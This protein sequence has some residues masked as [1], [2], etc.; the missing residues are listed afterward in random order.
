MRPTGTKRWLLLLAVGIIT[1]G[2]IWLAVR[3]G[4]SSTPTKAA[5]QTATPDF[6]SLP[7]NYL[8]LKPSPTKEF[9]DAKAYILVDGANGN[10]LLENDPDVP[11]SIGSTTK[12]VTALVANQ[13]FPADKI[14]TVPPKAAAINGSTIGLKAGEQISVKSLLQILL[15]P[16]GN[17]AAYTLAEVYS[18]EDGNYQKFVDAM[19]TYA[20]THHLQNTH[21]LDPAGLSDDGKSTAF[22]L[23]QIGRLVMNDP[24]LAAIVTTPSASVTSADGSIAYP[25]KNTDQLL[26]IGPYFNKNVIGI[27]TGFTPAAGYCLV[28][29]EKFHDHLL[30]AVVLGVPGNGETASAK[31]INK[32]FVWADQNVTIKSY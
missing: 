29:A 31:E 5:N 7:K 4:A 23:A 21:Y 16:S 3:S 20:A 26:Q 9:V 25:L 11:V 17:D 19:N 6:G 30:I 24:I 1:I 32:L 2:G 27:K 22:D 18:G 12:M 14:L 28:A 8:A 15:I 10:V 13:L